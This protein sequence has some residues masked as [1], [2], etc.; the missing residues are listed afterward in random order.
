MFRLIKA[1]WQRRRF[2]L[3]VVSLQAEVQLKREA[4]LERFGEMMVD[5]SKCPISSEDC[6]WMIDTFLIPKATKG[7]T[8]P[9]LLAL[10]NIMAFYWKEMKSE[11]DSISNRS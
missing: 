9:L 11:T 1:W 10:S 7:K 4:E 6:K 2:P 3:R 8:C 5:C